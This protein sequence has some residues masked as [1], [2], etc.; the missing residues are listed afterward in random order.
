MPSYCTSNIN[1]KCKKIFNKLKYPQMLSKYSK[2]STY[3]KF[4]LIT[5]LI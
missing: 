3:I 4:K 2:Y 5:N 1:L